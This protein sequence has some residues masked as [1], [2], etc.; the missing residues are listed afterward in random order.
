MAKKNTTKKKSSPA[1]RLPA[2]LAK[3]RDTYVKLFGT[4]PPLPQLQTNLASSRNNSRTH[5]ITIPIA[6]IFF[7]SIQTV[8]ELSPSVHV[9]R[10]G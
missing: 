3:F 8:R 2:D 4:L 10:N 1:K 6:R 5:S 7:Q 9:Y